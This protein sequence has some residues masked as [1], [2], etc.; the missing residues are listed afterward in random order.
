[1][2][3]PATT[4]MGKKFPSLRRE[5]FYL[6]RP[7]WKPWSSKICVTRDY[8]IHVQYL[9]CEQWLYP[10]VDFLNK[11]GN[12]DTSRCNRD[13]KIQVFSGGL[14]PWKRTA[15]SWNMKV[16]GSWIIVY[17][18]VAV[19]CFT[20]QCKFSFKSI[21]YRDNYPQLSTHAAFLCIF[22]WSNTKKRVEGRGSSVFFPSGT[23]Y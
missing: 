14:Q 18:K 23:G 17:M 11:G 1:M 19:I 9:R 7:Y 5:I 2:T 22:S 3:M 21:R 12:L 8:R 10:L 6:S 13:V 15:K 20:F 4:P 16:D